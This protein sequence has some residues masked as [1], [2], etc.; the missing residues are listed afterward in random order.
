MPSE[1]IDPEPVMKNAINF[2]TATKPF[3]AI[4]AATA[5]F[6]PDAMSVL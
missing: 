5:V 1:S 4:A 2:K 6:E 3:P